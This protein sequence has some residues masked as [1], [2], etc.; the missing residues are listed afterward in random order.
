MY[1]LYQIVL[2]TIIDILNTLRSPFFIL[3]LFIIYFQYWQLGKLEKEN[4]GFR[5]PILEKL[6]VSVI[7][8]IF[9]GII[10]TVLFIYLGVVAIPGDFIYILMVVIVLSFINPR[11]MCFSYGG[12][13]VSLS[14]LIFGYPNIQ[15]LPVMTIIA[16]LH[17]IES[18]LIL[19]DGWRN[20]LPVFFG[21]KSKIVSGFK[22]NR[23]WPI[24]FVIFIGDGL[25]H[26]IAFMAILSYEDY[27][28]GSNPRKKA[29]K[30]SFVLFI[31]SIIL[32]LLSKNVDNLFVPPLFALLG[33]E[34]IILLNEPQSHKKIPRTITSPRDY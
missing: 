24:P 27:S 21:A 23:F 5:K 17:I 20:K 33:H 2:F 7:Y 16:V 10:T 30:T 8:G 15:I 28:I 11:Y 12:A 34:Y 19:L 13:I 25:I 26:P 29:I 6:M 32:L 3:V 9:G 18:L 4:I 1:G 31:Y 14:N 22:M